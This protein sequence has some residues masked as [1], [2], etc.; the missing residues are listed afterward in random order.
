MKSTSEPGP[1]T[2]TAPG[3]ARIDAQ[4]WPTL[5]AKLDGA[6]ALT[7]AEREPMCAGLAE[8][9]PVLAD[10]LRRMLAAHA[11]VQAADSAHL[12]LPGAAL[13]Y[14]ALAAWRWV[15]QPGHRLGNY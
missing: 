13:L 6:L 5:S 4:R 2:P 11:G 7:S 10:A 15:P 9:Q 8:Q 3:A 14:A 12:V 1:A